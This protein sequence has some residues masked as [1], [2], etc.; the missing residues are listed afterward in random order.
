M[1][2]C[3]METD[4]ERAF[5]AIAEAMTQAG[6]QR[7]VAIASSEAERDGLSEHGDVKPSQTTVWEKTYQGWFDPT[8][9]EARQMK[10]ATNWVLNENLAPRCDQHPQIP[11]MLY[12]PKFLRYECPACPRFFDVD[13][14][15]HYR[16]ADETARD[17][18]EAEGWR[19]VACT[20]TEQGYTVSK[21]SS[22]A[23]CVVSMNPDGTKNFVCGNKLHKEAS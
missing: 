3:A 6:K 13:L 22:P 2:F 20:D 19:C 21:V 16:G 23:L 12:N 10:D 11:P 8:G 1:G 17:F 4:F 14:G 5:E 18:N 9:E 7:S 15:Y